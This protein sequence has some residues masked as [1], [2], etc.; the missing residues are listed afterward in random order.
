V[1]Q[2]V[3]NVNL[4]P[5]V[6]DSD[7]YRGLVAAE[8]MRILLDPVDTGHSAFGNISM[9]VRRAS[10]DDSTCTVMFRP[11]PRTL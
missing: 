3:A 5:I 8:M 7:D 1:R 4:L 10:A 11:E 2:N 6:L 9:T